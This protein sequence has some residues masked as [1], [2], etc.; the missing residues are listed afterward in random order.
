MPCC[1]AR[2][3]PNRMKRGRRTAPTAGHWQAIGLGILAYLGKLHVYRYHAP[4][5]AIT[6]GVFE[7]TIV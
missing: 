2:N 4:S 1:S 5:G 3:E 7:T 6:A